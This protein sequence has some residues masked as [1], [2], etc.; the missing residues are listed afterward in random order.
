MCLYY[1]VVKQVD[2]LALH[3]FQHY[4]GE[5]CQALRSSLKEVA[6]VLYSKKFVSGQER[7]QA[8]EAQGVTPMRKAYILMQVIER[9]IAAANSATMVKKFCRVL[10]RLHG[11]GAIVSRMKT[12][13]GD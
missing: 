4:Y 7:S 11:V 5:L 2:N 8:L 3:V 6:T 13:L 9:K 10:R 12:R 1:L